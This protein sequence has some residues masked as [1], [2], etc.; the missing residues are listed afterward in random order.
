MGGEQVIAT[1]SNY[2]TPVVG[3]YELFGKY[4]HLECTQ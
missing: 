2:I 4:A 1:S 3:D